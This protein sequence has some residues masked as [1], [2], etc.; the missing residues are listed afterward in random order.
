MGE[1]TLCLPSYDHDVVSRQAGH[2]E[3]AGRKDSPQLS[4]IGLGKYHPPE[5]E[6]LSI[7]LQIWKFRAELLI[8]KL[9]QT[10]V[11]P[12]GL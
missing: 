3:H 2:Q 1:L 11:N 5:L 7:S 9:V 8:E 12:M 4:T 10:F 6:T